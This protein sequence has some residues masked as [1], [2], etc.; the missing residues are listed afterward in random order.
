[1]G[2][3]AKARDYEVSNCSYRKAVVAGFSPRFMTLQ[4]AGRRTDM[5]SASMILLN[6]SIVAISAVV[7]IVPGLVLA[8]ID[9][10]RDSSV[11]ATPFNFNAAHSRKAV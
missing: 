6:L 9:S 5:F 7:I 11:S 4:L 10:L 1:M 8:H 3:R 2:T